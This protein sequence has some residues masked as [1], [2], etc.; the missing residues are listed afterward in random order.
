MDPKL[1]FIEFVRFSAHVAAK[2]E[3]VGYSKSAEPLLFNRSS[4]E[5]R[6]KNLERYHVDTSAEQYALANWPSPPPSPAAAD[7]R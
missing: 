7:E 6:V 3:H 2:F 4:L 1:R 5:Q